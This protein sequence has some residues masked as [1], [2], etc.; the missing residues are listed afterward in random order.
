MPEPRLQETERASA[1]IEPMSKRAIR[2][3]ETE[4]A[5]DCSLLL[6][7]VRAGAEVV[8]EREGEP[9]AVIRPAARDVR[10]LSESL[11]LSNEWGSNTT[12]EVQRFH[13]AFASR[14][15]PHSSFHAR[16]TDQ[17]EGPC[18]SDRA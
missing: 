11:R 4:A 9:V 10:F 2:V 13:N 1:R 7:H 6:A 14:C 12:L 5:R 3:S 15:A 18:H 16:R 8:I 17:G